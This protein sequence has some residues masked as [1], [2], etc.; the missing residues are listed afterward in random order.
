M[1]DKFVKVM[2]VIIGVLAFAILL[3]GSATDLILPQAAAHGTGPGHSKL[4]ISGRASIA[5]SS[6]GKYV[7][8][9]DGDR[10][11]RSKEFGNAGTW[12]V[13]AD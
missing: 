13:V 6:D 12:E 11:F 10:I 8:V 9:M 1:K 3:K 4:M 5:C 7:F 2:L